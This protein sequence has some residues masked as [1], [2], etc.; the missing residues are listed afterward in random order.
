MSLCCVLPRLRHEP[1]CWGD[2]DPAPMAGPA[3]ETGDKPTLPEPVGGP[4]ETD[5]GL[6]IAGASN[7]RRPKLLRAGRQRSSPAEGLGATRDPRM[8]RPAVILD[9]NVMI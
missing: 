4:R 7:F 8:S 9:Q 6:V 3:H 2:C 1:A 5:H